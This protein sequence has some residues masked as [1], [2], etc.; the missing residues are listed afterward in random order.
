MK[1]ITDPVLVRRLMF[2]CTEIKSSDGKYDQTMSVLLRALSNVASVGSDGTS[3][4][5]KCK[6]PRMSVSAKHLRAVLNND[7]LWA[8]R[9]INE[10]PMPLKDLWQR[11]RKLAEDLTIETLWEDLQ[12]YPM[13]TI[14]KEE[15]QRLRVV[16]RNKKAFSSSEERYRAA[17]IE[18]CK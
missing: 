2:A 10:H 14:T 8:S 7:K 16:G 12:T 15:D 11:W 18:L 4:S 5:V 6:N 1:R 17:S 9:T 3:F 13:V